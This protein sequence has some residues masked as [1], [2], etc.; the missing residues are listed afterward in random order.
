MNVLILAGYY[1]AICFSVCDQL[2]NILVHRKSCTD[3]PLQQ[4]YSY[5]LFS[6]RFG[7]KYGKKRKN[8]SA[9]NYAITVFVIF[10]LVIC[11]NSMKTNRRDQ[12]SLT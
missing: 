3:Y 9:R 5:D 7:N 4:F 8:R 1:D 2:E 6:K 12:A 11:L 10:D